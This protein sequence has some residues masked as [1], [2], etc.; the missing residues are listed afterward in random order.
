MPMKTP[1]L[2]L[3]ERAALDA[4]RAIIEVCRSGAHV[5]LKSDCSPVT[6]A[7]Q[8]AEDIILAHLRAAYPDIPIIAEE[9]VAAG[10]IPDTEHG[11]FFLVDPLDGT[12]EFIAQ[13]KEYT[14]NIALIEKGIPI[15]GIVYAPALG[16][17]FTGAAGIAEKLRV[18]DDFR[19]V[20]REA[21]ATRPIGSAVVA[22]MSRSH[23]TVET[24][25]Y[26]RQHAFSDTRSVG[27][28]LKFCL[29]AEGDADVYPRFGRTMEWDTAAGD[30]VLRAAGGITLG[31]DGKPLL[32]C[33]TRQTLDCAFA[34][35]H[36]VAWGR[37]PA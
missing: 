4:G 19:I 21:I 28:S 27:S 10:D 8:R 25:D 11:P 1:L 34:N 15:A 32:Y 36:F 20:D 35:P 7:D 6:E 12:R 18:D 30:A 37:P 2:A 31:L 33:K 22:V 17:A 29:L 13:S 5:T 14:V 26:L 24:E 16:V 9:A 23:N 3:F